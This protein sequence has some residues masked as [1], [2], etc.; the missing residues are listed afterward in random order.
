MTFNI[1]FGTIGTGAQYKY[2]KNFKS[3]KEALNFAKE[4]ASKYYYMHEG[5][6]GLPDFNLI[7]SEAKITGL[8]ISTLYDDHINDMMRWYVIP[9]ELDSIPENRLK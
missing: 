7:S 5:S 2:T 8:S 4:E 3:E 1:Y 9:T 6:H